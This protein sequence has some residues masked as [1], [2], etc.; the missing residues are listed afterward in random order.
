M[1]IVRGR[2]LSRISEIYEKELFRPLHGFPTKVRNSKLLALYTLRKIFYTVKG[3]KYAPEPLEILWIN[4]QSIE[5]ISTRRMPPDENRLKDLGS[6]KSGNWDNQPFNEFKETLEEKNNF[7]FDFFFSSMFFS[8]TSFHKSLYNHFKK[9][10]D[11]KE[12]K[13]Y[14]ICQ[15]SDL[16][17]YENMK[18]L[19]ETDRLFESIRDKGIVPQ[20]ELDRKLSLKDNLDEIMVDIGRDGEFLFVNGRH[21]LSIAKILGLEEIPVRIVCRHIKWQ[22]KREKAVR[23]PE[24]FDD[25]FLNHPDIKNLLKNN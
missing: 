24:E 5:K 22:E 13:Y 16:D 2:M 7:R 4:P 18:K 10:I 20:V 8:E 3:I 25:S 17:K 21:R 11:W 6:L 12:T 9:N 14:E 1:F 23:N 15:K 19:K